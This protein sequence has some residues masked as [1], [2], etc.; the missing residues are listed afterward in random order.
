M[1]CQIYELPSTR[2]T[3][4][5]KIL[6]STVNMV[7]VEFTVGWIEENIHRKK[8][9]QP[10]GA[11]Q[12]IV[13]GFHGLNQAH[14]DPAYFKIGAECDLWV[15]D[16]IAPV[17]IARKRGMKNAV[18]TPGPEIL[19]EFLKRADKKGY[20]S[21]FYGDSQKTLDALQK[22]IESDYSGHRVAGTFSPPFRPISPEEE[23]EHIDMI[24]ATNPD[25]VW[26]GLGLPKQDEWI[27][28]VKDRLNAPVAAGVGA[29]FG[30]LAGTTERAPEW[31]QKLN[32]EW[33]YMVVKKP[34]RTGKRVFIEGGQFVMSVLKEEIRLLNTR[35]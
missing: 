32:L 19:P 5:V 18:R 20:S 35:D 29:A 3:N 1:N 30:F 33:A 15:P 8:I 21:Y 9:E 24:N 23:Q 22:R 2:H 27:Y 31:V 28:R 17:F 7:D 4:P 34:K 6:N 10:S 25:V 12:L 26:V 14:R 16:S 11:C 13:T